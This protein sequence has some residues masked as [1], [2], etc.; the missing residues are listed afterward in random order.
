MHVAR[1]MVV[2]APL[3][4]FNGIQQGFTSSEFTTNF[5]RESLGE[6]S[7]GYVMAVFGATN[8]LFSIGIGRLADKLTSFFLCV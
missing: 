7:I 1:R 8:V 4:L 6:A 5:I 2:L 3:M